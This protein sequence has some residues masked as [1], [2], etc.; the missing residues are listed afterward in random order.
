MQIGKREKA[1]G[2]YRVM[3]L[4]TRHLA[5]RSASPQLTPSPPPWHH[6]HTQLPSTVLRVLS[7]GSEWGEAELSQ[8]ENPVI[9]EG[10][11]G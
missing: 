1:L 3:W 5:T 7:C 11:Y 9:C 8:E 10:E 2:A 6:G 4:C